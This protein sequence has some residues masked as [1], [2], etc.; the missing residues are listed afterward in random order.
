[1]NKVESPEHASLQCF[2]NCYI[3]ETGNGT[4]LT[5]SQHGQGLDLFLENQGIQFFFPVRYISPTERHLFDF[6]GYYRTTFEKKWNETDVTTVV[7]LLL[8][9]LSIQYES[10]AHLSETVQRV[11][12]SLDNMTTFFTHRE[13]E[14]A[15]P[16]TSDRTFIESEQSL[17]IGHLLHPT[18][19][20]RQGMDEQELLTY[21]PET[22]GTFHLHY[23]LVHKSIVETGSSGEQ[24]PTHLMKEILLEE[25]QKEMVSDENFVW[26]PL[27]PLQA[28]HLLQTE[29]V[30]DLLALG[31]LIN[32]GPM[33]KKVTATSSIRTVYLEEADVMLKLSIP[34]KVTNS[35]RV[36]KKHELERGLE[37]CQLLESNLGTQ[38]RDYFP[39]FHIINDPS[40]ITVIDQEETGFEV[41]FRENPFKGEKAKHTSLL[42][43][44]T[45]D[46]VR[47]EKSYL[48][49]VIHKIASEEQ[50]E[51]KEVSKDWFTQYLTIS[52]HPVLWLYFTHGIA[53]EAHQQNSIVRLENG[54]PVSFYYRDNQGYYFCQSKESHL[55]TFLPQL[56]EKS[57]TVCRDEIADERLRYYFFFNHLFGL[58][59]SF[60]TS[61]LSEEEVLLEILRRELQ[62]LQVMA[63]GSS[64]SLIDSLLHEESLPCKANLLTRFYD[65]DELEGD[66]A[67][68]SVYTLVKNPLVQKVRDAYGILIS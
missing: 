40:Y 7:S 53:L 11:L 25:E 42:A 2:L 10:S 32:A 5:N 19:K 63:Y 33:G 15:N 47:Q 1:M 22:R 34:V 48:A 39:N 16:Y 18:P 66:L 49:Q 27:H 38:L 64:S 60:G 46:P 29:K 50:R 67:S 61:G 62:D 9:E 8:K 14:G 6:P 65:M 59:N 23:L 20:S 30:K 21:S 24:S 3:R 55:Q 41:I 45:Q 51:I 35:L 36:N 13:Q 4:F 37:V 54:Y 57:D 31:L 12:M 52:L 26:F 28:K 58:I 44:L 56:N 17:L 43:G 68:Q